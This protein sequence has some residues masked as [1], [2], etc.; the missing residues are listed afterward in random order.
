MKCE[1][2]CEIYISIILG[3]NRDA[4]TGCRRDLYFQFYDTSLSLSPTIHQFPTG[5]SVVPDPSTFS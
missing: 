3:K 1:K 2:K 4:F 5:V